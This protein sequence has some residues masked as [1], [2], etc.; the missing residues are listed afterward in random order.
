VSDHYL[1]TKVM[2]A[3]AEQLQMMLYDG[4]IRF[5]RQGRDAL[6]RSDL[7]VSC[8][9][10]LRA[11]KIVMEMNT[12]LRYDVDPQLCQRLGSLYT[13]IYRRLVR[14]NVDHDQAAADEAVELL[15]YQRQTWAILMDR[16]PRDRGQT[17]PEAGRPGGAQPRQTGAGGRSG[18]AEP[19]GV[20]VAG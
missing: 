15:E 11:Q 16:L 8:D 3:S 10:L 19:V 12:A 17:G 14:A 5:A 6:A 9:R 18:P 2:T 13:Y 1:R 7:E 4:A 20:D